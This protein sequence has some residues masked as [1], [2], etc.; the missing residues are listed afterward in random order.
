MNN[1]AR[2]FIFVGRSGS[3]KG[4]QIHLLKD[5]ITK[6][7][8]EKAYHIEMGEILRNF[9]QEEGY[10]QEK[11]KD[12]TN[13][14]G[15]FQPD[16]IINSLLISNVMHFDNKES[17]LF[18]DGYPR[19]VF[20]LETLKDFLKYLEHKNAVF[21]N[22]EVSRQVSKERMLKRGRVDDH[23]EAINNRLD[24]YDNFVLP[25]I[26]VAK[27]DSFFNYLEVIGEDTVENIYKKII[28]N[29]GF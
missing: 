16:F 3:G 8:N 24:S 14:H 7:Y 6:K 17:V 28:E 4:T 13:N 12:S 11:A 19:N 9:F 5:F 23:E 25:M 22:I 21:V 1:K 10:I 2:V 18:F 27:K 29:L 15:N 20:Q 26:E